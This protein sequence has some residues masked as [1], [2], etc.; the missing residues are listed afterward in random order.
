MFVPDRNLFI[1]KRRFESFICDIVNL[2]Y[3]G[4]VCDVWEFGT[5][6]TVVHFYLF[7]RV[8]FVYDYVLFLLLLYFLLEVRSFLSLWR[9]FVVTSYFRWSSIICCKEEHF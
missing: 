5:R 6:E 4:G 1:I 8:N 9:V 2:S 3:G 7:R